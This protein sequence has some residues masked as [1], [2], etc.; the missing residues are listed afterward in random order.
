VRVS[1]WRV[2]YVE[3]VDAGCGGTAFCVVGDDPGVDGVDGGA[4]REGGCGG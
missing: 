3:G 2:G 4:F 1:W